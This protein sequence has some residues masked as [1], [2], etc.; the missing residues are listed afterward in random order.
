MRGGFSLHGLESWHTHLRFV[1]VIE[2]DLPIKETTEAPPER[3]SLLH[4]EGIWF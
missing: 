4:H 3:Q 1:I 2:A